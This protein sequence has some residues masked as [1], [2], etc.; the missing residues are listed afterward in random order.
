[1]LGAWRPDVII[2][3]I[4]MPH[5]NGY[6]FIRRLRG[7]SPEAGGTVPAVAVTAHGGVVDRIRVLSA[8]FQMHV[9]KPVEPAELVAA[10]AALVEAA[11][12]DPSSA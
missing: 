8:G 3:D 12:R 2:S 4:E 7:L 6:A 10:V 1:M 5:E 9:P 11:R